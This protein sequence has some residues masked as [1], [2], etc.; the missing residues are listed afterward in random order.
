M[1]KE[2]N[3]PE[4]TSQFVIIWF[5]MNMFVCTEAHCKLR[6]LEQLRSD[7]TAYCLSSFRGNCSS[8]CI[9]TSDDENRE[10]LRHVS[11]NQRGFNFYTDAAGSLCCREAKSSFKGKLRWLRCSWTFSSELN[12]CCQ[13]VSVFTSH[14]TK[15]ISVKFISESWHKSLFWFIVCFSKHIH[16]QTDHH[17]LFTNTFKMHDF[18]RRLLTIMDSIFLNKYFLLIVK[19]QNL[20]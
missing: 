20:S 8:S 1:S 9:K 10:N 3:W 5:I 18:W 17:K 4:N 19:K 7:L 16:A 12:P 11:W 13:E 2:R 14:E 15:I 6:W